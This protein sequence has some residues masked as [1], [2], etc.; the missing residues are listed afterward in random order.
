MRKADSSRKALTTMEGHTVVARESV[1]LATSSPVTSSIVDSA[2]HVLA[3]HAKQ[4]VRRRWV[5][6]WAQQQAPDSLTG[7][8]SVSSGRWWPSQ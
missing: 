5:C 3:L 6:F 1:F 4:H 2:L 8:G 7:P